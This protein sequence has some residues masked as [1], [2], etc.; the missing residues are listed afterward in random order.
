MKN[1]I[2]LIFITLFVFYSCKK[3]PTT[4]N[5]TENIGS[6]E[7]EN[8]VDDEDTVN[9]PV[10]IPPTD[11]PLDIANFFKDYEGVYAQVNYIRYKIKDSK[12]FSFDSMNNL[13][14]ENIDNKILYLSDNKIEL[15]E[16]WFLY[17]L[18]FDNNKLTI[19]TSSI[20]KKESFDFSTYN[21]K[22]VYGIQISKE[23]TGNYII[24]MDI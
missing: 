10:I 18:L 7:N 13:W 11:N 15:E 21:L 1:I 12:L 22:K 5:N 3:V 16:E 14:V 17:D 20:L 23:Y 4:P 2:L 6:D 8:V 24:I 9:P 19:L